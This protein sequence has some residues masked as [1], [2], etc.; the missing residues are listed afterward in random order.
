MLNNH[1]TVVVLIMVSLLGILAWGCASSSFVKKRTK[2]VEDMAKANK[3]QLEQLDAKLSAT[4]AK[5][6][7]ALSEARRALRKAE[8]AAG[9]V[10][11]QVIGERDVNFDFN[12]YD[13][14]KIAQDILDEIGATMQQRPA[15]IL[16]IEGHTD[17]I[18]SD[19]Y[20]QVLGEKRADNVKRFLADKYGVAIHRIFYI[21]HGESKP[22]VLNDT[23][24]GRATNRRAVLRLLGPPSE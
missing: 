20:N 7:D 19:A 15:L 16:E 21:S 6:D 5:A 12:R 13:L 3:A 24:T 10:N 23:R 18:G 17:N 1:R 9:Y 11:Y 4:D 2:E 22:K 8:E 14:T